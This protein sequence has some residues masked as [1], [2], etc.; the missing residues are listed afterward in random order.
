MEGMGGYGLTW[1]NSLP[2]T[3]SWFTTPPESSS[4][5][6]LNVHQLSAS[7]PA[8]ASEETVRSANDAA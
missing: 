7:S 3:G 6:M 8:P 2:A 5:S 1:P 4:K